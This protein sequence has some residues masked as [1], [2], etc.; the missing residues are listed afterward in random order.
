MLSS[1]YYWSE[2]ADN[3]KVDGKSLPV[4]LLFRLLELFNRT[5]GAAIIKLAEQLS[6]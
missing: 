5:E 1:N 3:K 2:Q 6:S 4:L